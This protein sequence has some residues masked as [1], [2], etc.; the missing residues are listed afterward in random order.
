MIQ[1]PPCCWVSH[2]L[3]TSSLDGFA[4]HPLEPDSTLPV[5]TNNK[6]EDG[7]PGS[8]VLAFKCFLVKNK[9]NRGAQQTVSSPSQPSLHRHNDEEEYR[10]PTALW[11]VIRVTGD[12]NVKEACEALAWDMVNSGLQVHW[13]DHQSADSSTQVLLMN[14]PLVLDRGGIENE[15]IWHLTE[16]KKALLKRGTLP[17]EYVGTPLLKLRVSWRPNKQGK[18]K[19]KA[20]RDLSLNKLAAFR[21]NGCLVC[22]VKAAEGSWPRLGPLWE[23]FHR[24]GL[25]WRALGRSC[26]MVI[27][28]NGKA[29]ES[30][31]VTMQRLHCCNV[32]HCFMTT[33]IVLPNIL[34]VHKRVK[35]EMADKSVPPHKFT[36]LC[37]EFMWLTLSS[38][39]NLIPLFDAIVPIALGHQLGSAI[40]TCR[41]NNNLA[42]VLIKK[43]K[44]SIPA[45][46]FGY[47]INVQGYRLETVCKLMESFDVDAALLACFS[48][49][50][51]TTL[52]V[53][54]T[55]GD[56]DE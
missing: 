30:D 4:L 24:T 9:S 8:A 20:D 39:D 37:Q 54:T 43:I 15:I 11:G 55:V 29:T 42:A 26:L 6:T 5:L 10:P 32:V 38:T 52:T 46:F 48:K 56:S 18:G 19:S 23:A 36:D 25:I 28:Y 1:R 45:W 17:A 35:I 12:R 53:M 27:M 50:D 47:W 2:C 7:F 41:S 22:T 21:E 49:F 16:I 3:W 14:V 31:R 51:S 40:V 44:C 13:K 34:T 33:H